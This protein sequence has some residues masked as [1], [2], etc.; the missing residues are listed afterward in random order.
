MKYEMN[1]SLMTARAENDRDN[2]TILGLAG[3]EVNTGDETPQRVKLTR[4]VERTPR[5]RRVWVSP[6]VMKKSGKARPGFYRT[7]PTGYAPRKFVDPTGKV[8]KNR[9]AFG[10]H[11]SWESR[12]AT[13][14]NKGLGYNKSEESDATT[15]A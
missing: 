2:I 8:W 5:G 12:R 13:L 4:G 6:T 14:P 15:T 3:I 1:G 9:L 7:I 10:V 11:K